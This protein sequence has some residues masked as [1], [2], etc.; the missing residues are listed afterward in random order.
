EVANNSYARG[1]VLTLANDTIGTG[2]RLQI[3][4]DNPEANRRI[5]REF[6][7]WARA[8]GLAQTLRTM[9]VSRAEDGEAFALLTTNPRLPTAVQ[10]DLRLIEADQVTSPQLGLLQ[11]GGDGVRLDEAGNPVAYDVL[12]HHPGDLVLTQTSDF[13]RVPAE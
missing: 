9:R 2:P 1:I 3:S 6:M 4:T 7:R 13:Y 8:V 5:E 12:Q 11:Q 10:L